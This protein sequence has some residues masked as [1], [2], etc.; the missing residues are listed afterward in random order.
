MGT[1]IEIKDP[2]RAK[3]FFEAKMSFTTGPTE[4][5]RM[6][7]NNEVNVVDVRAEED[8]AKGHVPGAVNLPKDQWSTEKGL[9]RDKTNVLYCYSIVCHL[10]AT[11]AVEF[12]GKGYPVM[13]LDGGWRWWQDDG[14]DIEK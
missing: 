4:L 13:E 1:Q 8:Y 7:K 9:R 3:S 10:A 14:Y 11:A 2:A 5:E 12:A 6:I